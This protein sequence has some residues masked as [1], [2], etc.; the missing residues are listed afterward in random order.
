MSIDSRFV[1]VTEYGAGAVGVIDTGTNKLVDQIQV[2]SQPYSL[3]MTPDGKR[4]YVA[5]SGSGTVSVVETQ[6]N[7]HQPDIYI[8]PAASPSFL[9]ITSD[10]RKV[11]VSSVYGGNITFIDVKTNR[12]LPYPIDSSPLILGFLGCPEGIATVPGAKR[13]I[14]YLNT[15]CTGTTGVSGHD[16]VFVIDTEYE[17]I[18]GV[19]GFSNH[20]NVGSGIAVSPDG[21]T[22]WV[23]GAN[24]CSAIGY[25][26]QGCPADRGDP[27]TVIDTTRNTIK[28]QFFLGGPSF[29]SFTPDSRYVY[30]A[31]SSGIVVIDAERYRVVRTLPILGSTGSVAFTADGRFA[32]TPIMGRNV[33]AVVR[34]D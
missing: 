22:V 33:V 25:D 10:G 23:S 3:V 26:H 24:A 4:L 11:L 27:V 2:G 5:N 30:L 15:Q 6:T 14:A 17:R 12:V 32:Y 21:K 34:T 1:Y 13:A 20:P 16:P 18:V 28:T 19:I 8:G 9:A 31:T 7:R 29:I